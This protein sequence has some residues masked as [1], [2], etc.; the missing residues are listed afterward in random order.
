MPIFRKPE[1]YA[2][3]QV[4]TKL[5][6]VDRAIADAQRELAGA[7]LAGVLDETDHRADAASVELDRLQTRRRVL[8]HA[9][10]DAEHREAVAL[11]EREKK[12]AAARLR[13]LKAH[14]SRMAKHAGEF[15]IAA[16]AMVEAYRKLTDAA[17]SARA[18]LPS[19]RA[20]DDLAPHEHALR[21]LCELQLARVGSRAGH[22]G[23]EPW[24]PGAPRLPIGSTP[25]TTPSLSDA[26][27]EQG[28]WL[29][30]RFA[31]A[32]GLAPRAARPAAAP[33]PS[34]P[35]PETVG[36]RSAT[37]TTDTSPVAEGSGE[38]SVSPARRY[39]LAFSEMG[40]L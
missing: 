15:E 32:S 5:A 25:D 11:A 31:I 4:R 9:L 24:A 37:P 20:F 16:A 34:P 33:M 13:A 26:L 18:L 3:E 23:P 36:E 10:A 30:E 8:L 40:R 22:L 14:Q 39:G 28:R 7:A 21:R 17:A 1:L 12:E 38:P 35:P 27:V 6:E 29:A 2:V 19:D